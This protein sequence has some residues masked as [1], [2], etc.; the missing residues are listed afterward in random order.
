MNLPSRD[1]CETPVLGQRHICINDDAATSRSAVSTG[2]EYDKLSKKDYWSLAAEELKSEEHAF[3]GTI[4]A[5]QKA[6]A[7]TDGDV[8][9][10][11]IRATER[12]HDSML[13]KQWRIGLAGKE[14]VVRDQL[15]KLLK[16]VKIFKD[17]AS[18][19]AGLDPTHAA[20]PWAG[21]CLIMQ[22]STNDSDQYAAM[23]AGAEEVS[24]IVSRYTEIEFLYVTREDTTLKQEFEA[25]RFL[26][27][28]PNLDDP[29]VVLSDIRRRDAACKDIGEVFNSQDARVRHQEILTIFKLHEEKM[30]SLIQELH[31]P[32]NELTTQQSTDYKKSTGTSPSPRDTQPLPPLLIAAASPSIDALKHVLCVT[33]DV[34][35]IENGSGGRN[36][37]HI[38]AVANQPKIASV[39]LMHGVNVH[40]VAEGGITPL[41]LACMCGHEEVVRVLIEEGLADPNVRDL[42]QFTPLHAAATNGHLEVTRLLLEHGADPWLTESTGWTPLNAATIKKNEKV[43]QALTQAMERQNA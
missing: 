32:R 14:I 13:R 41:C 10:Q 30:Y 8:V 20:I 27:S 34:N 25:L 39:L 21:V 40:A 4:V 18:V 35:M 42:S 31:Q 29:S 19:A 24:T 3:E 11:L 12:S 1:R 15:E 38:A 26:R 9:S 17:L 33:E 23:V 6:V 28:I 36:A 37:L 2:A 5:V 16:A 22:L 7:Q 43:V